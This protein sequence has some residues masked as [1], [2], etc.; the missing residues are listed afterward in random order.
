MPT[1]PQQEPAYEQHT[2]ETPDEVTDA[3]LCARYAAEAM[4]MGRFDL[5]NELAQLAQRA[6]RAELGRPSGTAVF[7]T[8]FAA[9]TVAVPLVGSTRDEQ[10]AR[11][12]PR[13]SY[14]THIA[15]NDDG[16]QRPCFKPIEWNGEHGAYVHADSAADEDHTALP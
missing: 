9:G 16:S 7:R 10:P 1:W 12:T 13:G 15:P 14:C 4:L 2:L 8:E 3:Q 6:Q 11:P 5:G